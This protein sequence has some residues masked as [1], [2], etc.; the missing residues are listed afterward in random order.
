MPGS[1]GAQDREGACVFVRDAA[2]GMEGRGSSA[3]S[4]ASSGASEPWLGLEFRHLAALQAVAD[5]GSFNGA[6]RR[7][8]YTQSAISQQIASLERIVGVRVVERV[9]GRKTLGLSIAGTTLLAHAAAI[10]ARLGAAKNDIDAL[11]R[12]TAGPLRIGAYESV[13]TRLLPGI[14]CRFVGRYP[15]VEVELA[16]ALHDLDFLRLLERGV[17]DLAFV[18][19]PLPDGPFE[20]TP[21]LSDPYVLVAQAGSEHAALRPPSTLLDLAR[22]PLICF[23]A[24]KRID[25]VVGQLR[26]IGMDTDVVLVSDYN[27]AVQGYAAAGLGVSFMPRL[28]VNYDD[29]RTVVI[30]LGD[31]IPPR[32]IA[33]AWH[34]ELTTS[35]AAKSLMTIAAEY[36]A[37]LA[38]RLAERK[39]AA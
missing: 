2:D 38:A 3:D 17:L 22:L 4:G 13:S 31:L 32:Q 9:H 35:E 36:G 6:A 21:V 25:S 16:E 26:A 30:E 15:D 27:E 10:Q 8:G 37:C 18:D 7:L 24:C 1:S 33:V 14:L 23:R 39:P 19:L 29:P 34:S 12:G 11:A 5:E 20:T 28:S